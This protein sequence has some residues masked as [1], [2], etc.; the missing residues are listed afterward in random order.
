MNPVFLVYRQGF[1]RLGAALLRVFTYA[2]DSL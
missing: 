1:L 2:L